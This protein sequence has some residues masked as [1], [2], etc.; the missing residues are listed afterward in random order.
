MPDSTDNTE[1][2]TLLTIGDTDKESSL[3]IV[4][5]RTAQRIPYLIGEGSDMRHLTDIRLHTQLLVG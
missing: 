4:A 5:E 2:Q 3:R 1:F